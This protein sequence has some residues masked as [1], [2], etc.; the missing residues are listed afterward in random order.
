MGHEFEELSSRIL[1]AAIAVHK[2]L[3][4]GFLESIYQKA[5]VVALN[6]RGLPVKEQHEVQVYF[7]DK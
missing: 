7:E 2:S 1:E 5:M 6:H 4:P 3:G